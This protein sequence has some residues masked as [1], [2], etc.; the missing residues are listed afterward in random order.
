VPELTYSIT[1]D[2][3]HIDA[4]FI[5]RDPLAWFSSHRRLA[6]G[7]D[8][9]YRYCYLFKYELPLP[10]GA[11]TLTLPNN[12]H[13]RVFAVTAALDDNAATQT[14]WPLYDDFTGRPPVELRGGSR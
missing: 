4:G 12:P 3:D 1:N 14:A 9:I 7:S 13:I 5:K 2:L 10:A 6:D 11:K 8:D